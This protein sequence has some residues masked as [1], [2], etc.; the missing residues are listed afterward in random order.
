[1]ESLIP[2]S[3]LEVAAM[4]DCRTQIPAEPIRPA[5]EDDFELLQLGVDLKDAKFD[6][7]PSAFSR[8]PC[9][10]WHGTR[11]RWRPWC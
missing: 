6:T 3:G 11:R 10:A 1:M 8:T 5:R 7:P 4:T 2:V 9:C